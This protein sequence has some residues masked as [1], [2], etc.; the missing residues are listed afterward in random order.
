MEPAV[1]RLAPEV[2]P[3]AVDAHLD[4][5]AGELVAGRAEAGELG[6]AGDAAP[7]GGLELVAVDVGHDPHAAGAA[8]G[9][10]V[11]EIRS[12]MC[13]CPDEFGV[14]VTHVEAGEHAAPEVGQHCP[15]G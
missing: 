14:R 6:V 15:A 10:L 1:Q 8:H 2:I 13:G 3:A 9:A 12:D 5:E 11:V 4:V 7:V